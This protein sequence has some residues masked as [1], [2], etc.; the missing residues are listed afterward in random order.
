MEVM[1][2]INLKL[3]WSE[4]GATA[5]SEEGEREGKRW[6]D[7]GQVKEKGRIRNENKRG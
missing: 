5:K 2:V 4:L 6:R 1:T 3:V 7:S